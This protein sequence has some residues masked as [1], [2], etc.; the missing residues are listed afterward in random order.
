M[1]FFPYIISL[2]FSGVRISLP[3]SGVRISLPFSG[4][5]IS[6]S[7]SGVR[8][9]LSF[10]GVRIS[11]PF[12]GVRI[13]LS[14]VFCALLSRQLF[15][16]LSFFFCTVLSIILRFTISDY[17]LICKL[18]MPIYK[19]NQSYQYLLNMV[20]TLSIVGSPSVIPRHISFNDILLEP[21]LFI[22]DSV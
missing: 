19:T 15:V 9:S 11:L 7:F 18:F 2:P 14:L 1:F 4:V 6:L 16:L 3:F 17:S 10:S 8:I 5:R 12:S 13:S 20:I 21:Y 22:Q